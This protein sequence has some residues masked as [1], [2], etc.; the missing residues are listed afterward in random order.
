MQNRLFFPQ[1][2]LD[3]WLVDERIDIQGAEIGVHKA[4]RR[5]RIAE[6]MRVV[7][8]VTGGGDPHELIGRVKSKAFLEELGAEIFERSMVLGDFAYDVVPGWLA[9]PVGSFTE[10]L[11]SPEHE[12]VRSTGFDAKSEEDLLTHHLLQAP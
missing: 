2:A 4:G 12:L 11:A 6:A 7:R 1:D 5:Y 10:Y 3:Q 8:E 9:V